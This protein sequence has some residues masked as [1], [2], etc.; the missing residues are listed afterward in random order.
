MA[1]DYP[2]PW[3]GRHES[4]ESSNGHKRSRHSSPPISS[5]PIFSSDDD[6]SCENYAQERRKKKF[7][8]PWFCQRPVLSEVLDT[9]P[10]EPTRMRRPFQRHYDSGVFMGSD[11]LDMDADDVLEKLG[12]QSTSNFRFGLHTSRLPPSPEDLVFQYIQ[13]CLEEG[14]E[15]IDLSCRNLTN[16]SNAMIKPLVSFTSVPSIGE[17]VFSI[18]EPKLKIFLASNNLTTLPFELFQLDRLHVLS[19]RGNLFHELPPMIGNLFNLKELN[20]SQNGLRYLPYE[21][22]NLFSEDC[23]LETLH[24]HPNLFYEPQLDHQ[25]KPEKDVAP[26]SHQ[27]SCSNNIRNSANNRWRITYQA[28]TEVRFL[29]V[30]GSLVKGPDFVN[31]SSLVSSNSLPVASNCYRPIPPLPRGNSL[32]RV[33]SLA[34]TALASFSKT[35]ESPCLAPSLYE[36]SPS[37]FYDLFNLALNKKHSGGSSCTVCSRNFIIPRTEWIEWWEISKVSSS[38]FT[39]MGNR[40]FNE[41]D[42]AERLI[43]FVR[44]GCSWLCVPTL[45]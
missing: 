28:R 36:G 34:E 9:I 20:L 37:H 7:R 30:N 15:T 32:S 41:R 11:K 23:S 35:T 39:N 19:L 44:R 14:N 4:A 10:E 3:L 31:S 25:N 27:S 6:P 13:T 5:D 18:L 1:E 33:P 45:D 12:F 42:D 17:R 2:L 22:L 40:V 24:L 26:E 38:S 8:G 43:P 16:L 21:I 29:E